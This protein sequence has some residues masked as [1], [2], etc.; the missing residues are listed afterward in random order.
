VQTV[1]VTA[2]ASG[3]VKTATVT[4]QPNAGNQPPH[5]VSVTP[6]SGSGSA[7]TFAF[8]YSDPNGYTELP[9]AEV[10]ISATTSL[11]N[12]CYIH[13][14]RA[15]N[16]LWLGNDAANAWIGPL[17]PG[18]AGSI[19]NSQCQVNAATSSVTGAGNDLTLNL[20]VTF[21]STFAGAKSIYMVTRNTSG[22]ST[23]YQTMGS[24]TVLARRRGP[25][26]LPR[27]RPRPR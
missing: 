2:S 9:W 22:M 26:P 25:I 3:V 21:S 1:T 20:A 14:D 27:P 15:G 24:Y 13:Y 4:V 19:Q 11:T 12:A 18:A 8:V 6:A 17:L 5:L 7:Q 16:A 23:G 10:V